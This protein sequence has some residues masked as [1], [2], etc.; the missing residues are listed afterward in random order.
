MRDDERDL[1]ATYDRVAAKYADTF[2]DELS[3]K[4]FD[5]ALLDRYAELVRATEPSSQVWDLGC[6]PGHVG[7]YLADRGLDVCGLDLS[8]QMVT[9][10]R[11]LN[12]GMR[13]VRGSMLALP[14]ADGTLAGIVSFYAIHHLARGEVMTALR[15]FQRALRSGG[16]LLLGFH[17][18]EGELLAE[19]MLG[20]PVAFHATLY[21]GD[22]LA[23]YARRA[24]FAAVEVAERAPYAFEHPT[25]RVYLLGAKP[26]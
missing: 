16:Q 17:G 21:R 26:A 14:V 6:G 12:P 8:E 18:G 7:R 23:Q 10:A 25:Q 2:N 19:E 15:E 3:H 13:F 20:E 11:R 9:I 22:E 1:Q 5:R 24:G 4:P